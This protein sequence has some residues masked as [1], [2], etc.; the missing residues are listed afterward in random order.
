MIL[1]KSQQNQW[2]AND[3]FSVYEFVL[4]KMSIKLN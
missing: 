1:L 3:T 2:Q 4:G